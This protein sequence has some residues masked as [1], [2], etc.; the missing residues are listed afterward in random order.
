MAGVVVSVAGAVVV[1]E[2]VF[3]VA[4]WEQEALVEE[5]VEVSDAPVL[6]QVVLAAHGHLDPVLLHGQADR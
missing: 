4:A 3:V 1:V 2:V 5:V 6:V